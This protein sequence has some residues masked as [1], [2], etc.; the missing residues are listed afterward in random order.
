MYV[1]YGCGRWGGARADG[2]CGGEGSKVEEDGGKEEEGGK[3]SERAE[4]ESGERG[5]R[6]EGSERGGGEGGEDTGV[7]LVASVPRPCSLISAS[8]KDVVRMEVEEEGGWKDVA[9]GAEQGGWCGSESERGKRG[10]KGKEGLG[11]KR[12][13]QEGSRARREGGVKRGRERVH[14][15]RERERESKGGTRREEEE[16][17]RGDGEGAA[18]T[19]V[20]DLHLRGH[21]SDAARVQLSTRTQRVARVAHALDRDDGSRDEEAHRRAVI[22]KHII[23]REVVPVR[24]AQIVSQADVD[25]VV[26]VE[27]GEHADNGA[28]AGAGVAE[29]RLLR[30]PVDRRHALVVLALELRRVVLPDAQ[31]P[32]VRAHVDA[33]QE[34]ALG[35]P[36]VQLAPDRRVQRVTHRHVR[37]RRPRVGAAARREEQLRLHLSALRHRPETPS[38]LH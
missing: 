8:S 29:H 5:R 24:L 3:E 28:A 6:K 12:G 19:A 22:R 15:K 26:E 27:V 21:V 16:Q 18:Q 20:I 37:E 14:T 2:V 13:E 4:E 9:R 11:E 30:E 23:L 25:G 35:V 10:V 31:V 17:G 33:A 32:A 36:L 1:R 34:A 38:N 7:Y